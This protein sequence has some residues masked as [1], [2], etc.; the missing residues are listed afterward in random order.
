MSLIWRKCNRCGATIGDRELCDHCEDFSKPPTIANMES[1]EELIEKY[2]KIPMPTKE[3]PAPTWSKSTVELLARHLQSQAKELESVGQENILMYT[4]CDKLDEKIDQLL[5]RV[6]ELEGF[7]TSYLVQV[8][9]NQQLLARISELEAE[10][11]KLIE[12]VRILK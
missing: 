2:I 6:I 9:E 11:D 7:K 5:D 4:K 8:N 10:K 12:A 1:V 3:N